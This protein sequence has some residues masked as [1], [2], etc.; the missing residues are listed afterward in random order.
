MPPPI[1]PAL[2]EYSHEESNVELMLEEWI[3]LHREIAE[4]PQTCPCGKKGI[5]EL[6]YIHNILTRNELC[7]GNCCVLQLNTNTYGLCSECKLYMTVSHTA[8]KCKFCSHN[9]SDAPTGKI[10]RGKWR[11]KFYD[12][13]ELKN[14]GRWAIQ[15]EN[16]RFIDPHYLHWLDNQ[17][18]IRLKTAVLEAKRKRVAA[19]QNE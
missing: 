4:E 8:H 5:R 9:R 2:F 3:L 14:Y 11:G 6:C 16:R 7:I 15:T 12:D 19:V 10:T 13:P 18:E 17:E 1:Y